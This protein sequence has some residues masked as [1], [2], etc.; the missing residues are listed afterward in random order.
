M[1]AVQVTDADNIMVITNKGMLIRMPARDISV[2]GRNTQGV[3]LIDI[4]EAEEKVVGLTRVAAEEPAE[5]A[6]DVAQVEGRTVASDAP[7]SANGSETPETGDGDE[8][9]DGE[10]GSEGGDA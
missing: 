5:V 2:I 3:R 6:A 1:G 9:E 7:P 8:P 4:G 10:G